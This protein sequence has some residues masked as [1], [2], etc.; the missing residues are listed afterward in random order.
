MSGAPRQRQD[1]ASGP[2]AS[3]ERRG[4]FQGVA[5][6]QRDDAAGLDLA[7][8]KSRADREGSPPKAG[9][10]G[11]EWPARVV[12]GPQLAAR[13]EAEPGGDRLDQSFRFAQG[14]GKRSAEGHGPGVIGRRNRLGQA[15]AM[16]WPAAS[17]ISVLPSG[18]SM[19]S[20]LTTAYPSLN[21]PRIPSRRWFTSSPS[22]G[23]SRG[24][25]ERST[26]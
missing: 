4:E 19:A 25:A 12:A 5:G 13:P 11:A 20:E 23:V 10:A 14:L 7:R 2:Q 22:A 1:D 6:G 9:I 21:R 26:S 18:V 15:A 3:P 24:P 8:S 16:T 17:S